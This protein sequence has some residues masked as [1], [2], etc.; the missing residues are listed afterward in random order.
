MA[1]ALSEEAFHSDPLPFSRSYPPACL[2]RILHA[3]CKNG[4]VDS[5]RLR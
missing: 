4:E 3:H 1:I 5:L 2:N